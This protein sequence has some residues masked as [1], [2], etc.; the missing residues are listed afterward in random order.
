MSDLDKLTKEEMQEAIDSWAGALYTILEGLENASGVIKNNAI[1]IELN[2]DFY[3]NAC[4]LK[5]EIE[6][7]MFIKELH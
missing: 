3:N 5:Q 1:M 7:E 6:S 4:K 2:L